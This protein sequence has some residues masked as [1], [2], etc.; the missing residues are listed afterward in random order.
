MQENILEETIFEPPEIKM[1]VRIVSPTEEYHFK[2]LKQAV[3]FL[4]AFSSCDSQE[5][6]KMIL[7]RKNKIGIWKIF[8]D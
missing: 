6:L 5:C 1:F 7:E 8:Y 3:N 4:S 2:N